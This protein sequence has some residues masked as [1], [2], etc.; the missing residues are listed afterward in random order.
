VKVLY[1]RTL[2]RVS[3]APKTTQRTRR[4]IKDL[5]TQKNTTPQIARALKRGEARCSV[6]REARREKTDQIKT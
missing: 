4:K 3:R 2:L 1:Y 6:L 5:C